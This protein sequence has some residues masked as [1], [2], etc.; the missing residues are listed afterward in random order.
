MLLHGIK[1]LFPYLCIKIGIQKDSNP[2]CYREMKDFRNAFRLSVPVLGA[3]WFLGASYGLLTSSMDYPVWICLTMALV[4]YSGSVEFVGLTLL[5]GAFHPF[6]ALAMALMIGARH[7]FYGISM[8]DR[9][10]N[11]G[12]MKPLLIFWMSDETFAINYTHGGPLQQ[13][14]WL[15]LLDYLYWFCGVLMGY[16][17]GGFLSETAMSCLKG[18]E[19]VVTAMFVAIFMDDYINHKDTHLSA[20]MGIGTSIVCLVLFGAQQFIVPTMLFTLALLYV[21]YRKEA[22]S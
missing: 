4:V 3:Y 1:G 7:I 14:L 9:W 21:R 8:L 22:Q 11:A 10:R 6:A 20:W 16:F 2:K 13:Q 5:C 12:W 15:S 19:F 17:V 18:V